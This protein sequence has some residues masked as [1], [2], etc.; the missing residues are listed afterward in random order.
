MLF[1]AIIVM[2]IVLAGVISIIVLSRRQSE[3]IT[4]DRSNPGT[5]R[6]EYI[7]SDT[8][9]GDRLKT[10]SQ[11]L[12]LTDWGYRSWYRIPGRLSSQT[13]ELSQTFLTRDQVTAAQVHLETG[14]QKALLADLARIRTLYRTPQGVL[15]DYLTVDESGRTILSNKYSIGTTL[16]WLRLM[17][18]GYNLTGSENLLNELKVSSASF[19]A[20]SGDDGLLPANSY[21]AILQEAPRVDPAATPTIRPT[22][23]PTPIVTEERAVILLSDIDL[24]AMKLLVPLDARWTN[25]FEKQRKILTNAIQSGPMPFF[26]YAYDPLRDEY[27]GFSGSQPLIQTEET[28]LTLLH[29]YEA[30]ENQDVALSYIR[31]QFYES[32][33]LYEQYHRATGIAATT[34]ECITGY[35]LLARIARIVDDQTLYRKAT[36]RLSWHLATNTRSAAYGTVFRTDDDDR[37]KV[38]AR[39]NLTALLVFR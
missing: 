27:I 14:D 26:A 13:A 19:L 32:G 28:L 8:T 1:F 10:N 17:A 23:S 34:D 29:L 5:A 30:S 7:F 4:F 39:D 15:A 16:T 20:L 3:T 6:P 33:A 38:W 35:A 21:L 18:E 11:K 22:I 25:L 9:I 24:Y 31:S 37:V 36:A 12:L 2:V